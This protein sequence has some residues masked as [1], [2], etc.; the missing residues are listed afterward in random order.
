MQ[1]HI[2][3][4]ANLCREALGQGTVTDLTRL[5]GGASMESWRFRYG[6]RPLILRRLPFQSVPEAAVGPDNDVGAIS[7]ATQAGLIR[8]LHGEGLKVPEVI[9]EFAPI[10]RWG[11]VSS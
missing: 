4:L 8:H 9:G 1:E 11:R 7:L 5:S 6:D 3:E 2:D 10:A